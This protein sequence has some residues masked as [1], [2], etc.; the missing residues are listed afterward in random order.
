MAEFAWNRLKNAM[1]HLFRG[2]ERTCTDEIETI[3]ELSPQFGPGG[4]TV[5]ILPDEPVGYV[6]GMP[7]HEGIAYDTSQADLPPRQKGVLWIVPRHVAAAFKDREDFV[8]P[9]RQIRSE[10]GRVIGSLILRK[11]SPR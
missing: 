2:V 5:R 9:D 7:L 10:D 3:L 1:R 11:N 8:F 6:M 4:S